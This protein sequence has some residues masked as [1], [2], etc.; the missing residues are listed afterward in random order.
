MNEYTTQLIEELATKL[1][2]TSEYLWGVLKL[3]APLYSLTYAI[4]GVLLIGGYLIV[5]NLLNKIKDN[6]PRIIIKAILTAFFIILL[7]TGLAEL[8]LALAGL[9]NSDFWALNYVLQYVR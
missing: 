2:T 4:L 5:F 1:G 7:T 9:F 6:Q 3:Q 8:P